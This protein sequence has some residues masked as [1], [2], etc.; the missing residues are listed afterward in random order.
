M[1][2]ASELTEAAPSA[3]RA[4]DG[5]VRII[6]ASKKPVARSDRRC[7]GIFAPTDRWLAVIP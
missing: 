5:M 4:V 7:A 3:A 2:I 1:K 6:A